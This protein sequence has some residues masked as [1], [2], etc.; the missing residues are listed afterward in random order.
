MALQFTSTNNNSGNEPEKFNM[1][2]KKEEITTALANSQEI[3]A[4]TSTINVN[5][6]NSL[7]SFGSNVAEEISKSSDVILN[8]MNIAQVNESGE[9]LNTLTKIMSKFDLAEIKD[10]DK[11]GGLFGNFI[12]NIKKEIDKILE[13]YNTMGDEIDK[14]YVKLKEYEA[15]IN[16]SNEKLEN[17]FQSN[18]QTYQELVKYIMAGE[19]AVKEVDEYLVQAQQNFE[20]SQNNM[21]KFDIQNLENAK[22]I[23]EQRV[24]DLKIAENIA[25]Q[26]VPMIKSM[27]FSNINLNRKINSAFIITIPVFKQ[28][29]AQAILLKRQKIQAES[30]KAL[31]EKTNEMLIKN[32]QNTAEQT[33]LA[34]QLANGSSVQIETLE[35]TWKTIV[36]GIDE[37]KKIQEEA[38]RKREE[39]AIA[40]NRLKE[41]FKAKALGE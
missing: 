12:N 36:D 22:S 7:V 35:K 16:S 11:K 21:I 8:S 19:Q 17:L 4:L 28:A 23:L 10:T 25:M 31:D 18:V 29:L 1:L 27:E 30:M 6:T 5:D 37:T 32:A 20:Q 15:E 33:K 9:L 38:K 34:A 41:E 40:L 2:A 39:D 3:D 24:H 14:I 13:K 26:S